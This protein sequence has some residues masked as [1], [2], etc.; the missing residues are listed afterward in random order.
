MFLT[1]VQN[2]TITIIPKSPPLSVD[3]KLTLVKIFFF[4]KIIMIVLP[5]AL[6]L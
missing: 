3:E 4:F 1:T 2:E 5:A 6:K